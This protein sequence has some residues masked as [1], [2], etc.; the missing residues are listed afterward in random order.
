MRLINKLRYWYHDFKKSIFT[1][2]GTGNKITKSKN[3]VLF[4][5]WDIE[6]NNNLIE[7]GN[8]YLKDVTIKIRGNNHQIKIGDEVYMYGGILWIEDEQNAIIIDKNTSIQSAHLAVTETGRKINIGKNCM[9]AEDIIIRTGDS[10]PIFDIETKN[11]INGGKDVYIGDHVWIG[12]RAQILK[13]VTIENDSIIGAGS[14]VVQK[15]EKNTIVAGNPAKI[16][17]TSINWN[18]H[19]A[20]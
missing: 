7:F 11:I 14:I 15:V 10:H 16:V 6:G 17:K 5:N 1:I 3:T 8:C 20:V 9:L 13:G 19:R 12:T 4:V 18:S 2:R